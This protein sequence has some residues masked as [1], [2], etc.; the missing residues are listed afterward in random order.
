MLRDDA[1]VT[2]DEMCDVFG[3]GCIAWSCLS[4]RGEDEM[5]PMRQLSEE[6]YA[7][8]QGR[9]NRAALPFTEKVKCVIELQL[10]LQPIYAQ[11]GIYIKP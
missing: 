2:K 4:R 9:R 8:T 3:L 10:R 11:R 5:T 7:K 6:Q 1:V